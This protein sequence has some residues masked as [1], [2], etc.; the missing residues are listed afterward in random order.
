[1]RIN[2]DKEFVSR[3]DALDAF[4]HG[5]VYTS[6]DAQRIVRELPAMTKEEAYRMVF[7]DLTREDGCALFRGIYDAKNGKSSYMH[8]VSSVM[9]YIASQVSEQVHDSFEDMFL[10]NMMKSEERAEKAETSA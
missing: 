3:P 7:A 1:M 6:K 9:E 2:K 8:G 4:G 10:K 5:S